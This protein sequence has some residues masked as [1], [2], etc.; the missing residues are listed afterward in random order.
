[1]LVAKQET[2]PNLGKRCASDK[3]RT[4]LHPNLGPVVMALHKN[5]SLGDIE[6]LNGVQANILKLNNAIVLTNGHVD[7][8]VDAS[9]HRIFHIAGHLCTYNFA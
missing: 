7:C 8:Q 6:D 3:V 2:T 5:Y 9:F 1:M 4:P